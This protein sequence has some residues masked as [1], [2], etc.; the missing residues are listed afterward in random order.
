MRTDLIKIGAVLALLV[1]L[2]GLEKLGL[3][4]T[5]MDWLRGAAIKLLVG[6]PPQ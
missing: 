5:A 1:A 3:L 6:V 2:A 4:P